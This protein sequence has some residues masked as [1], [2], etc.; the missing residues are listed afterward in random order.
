MRSNPNPKDCLVDLTT[1]DLRA[2]IESVESMSG[3]WRIRATYAPSPESSDSA[4]RWAYLFW[5]GPPSA[6]VVPSVA[7]SHHIGGYSIT[8]FDPLE[9]CASGVFETMECSDL[10]GT[11]EL[12][13]QI[14]TEAEEIALDHAMPELTAF[15]SC[16][17]QIHRRPG[18]EPSQQVV[19][20]QDIIL[21]SMPTDAK[22][23]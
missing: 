2:I 9:F 14:V 8:V 10:A 23:S 19:E 18:E 4:T 13:R 11:I 3:C 22:H 6:D 20:L 16:L 21:A 15:V 1:G 7:I 12:I 17:A 5:A